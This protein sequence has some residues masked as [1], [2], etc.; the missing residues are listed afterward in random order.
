LEKPF[1]VSLVIPRLDELIELHHLGGETQGMVNWWDANS[2]ANTVT[3]I[4]VVDT[5]WEALEFA[6]HLD[7]SREVFEVLIPRLVEF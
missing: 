1:G 7:T 6:M 2:L 3:T 5:E 4:M